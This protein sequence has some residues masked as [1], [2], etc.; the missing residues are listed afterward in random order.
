MALRLNPGR[1]R[2][3][4]GIQVTRNIKAICIAIILFFAPA[5]VQA[6]VTAPPRVLSEGEQQLVVKRGA[7]VFAANCTGYC[8][9]E[10]GTAGSGAPALAN[11]GFDGEYIFKTVMYGVPG[12][13]MVGW[14]QRIPKDD[15][16]AVIAYVKSL[17]GIVA[18]VGKPAPPPVLTPAGEHGR[19]LFFDS[20]RGP[21]GVLE[22]PSGQRQGYSGNA[23]DCQ[24]SRRRCGA[25]KSRHTRCFERNRERAIVPRARHFAGSGADEVIRSDDRS[26]CAARACAFRRETLGSRVPGN[27]PP[28]WELIPTEICNRFSNSCVRRVGPRQRF[29][30]PSS[31]LRQAKKSMP[32]S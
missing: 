5:L 1:V 9:G 24:C 22:L 18:A 6:Q 15:S 8:H 25:A 13:A 28:C 27:I 31:P 20:G 3:A 14:G 19:D 30:R 12:T 16:A 2:A 21:H 29:L 11:R 32:D 17:N 26:A 23:A 4:G 7:A 10:N